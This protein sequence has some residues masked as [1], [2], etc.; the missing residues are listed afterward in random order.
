[1][2]VTRVIVISFLL[3]VA[4]IYLNNSN[5]STDKL[6]VVLAKFKTVFENQQLIDSKLKEIE[7]VTEKIRMRVYRKTGF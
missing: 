3:I 2:G 1:M 7:S 4:I 5:A 6:N